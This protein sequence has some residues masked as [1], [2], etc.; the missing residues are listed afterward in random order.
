MSIRTDEYTTTPRVAP[1]DVAGTVDI[2][3]DAVERRG[4]AVEAAPPPDSDGLHFPE[5]NWALDKCGFK[6]GRAI[7]DA[8]PA[9]DPGPIAIIDV[10]YG[11]LD[12]PCIRHVVDE[13]FERRGASSAASHAA[14]V[15][16]VIVS[17]CPVK[18]VQV[19]NSATT[20]GLD[21]NLMLQALRDIASPTSR[22]RVLNLSIGWHARERALNA[23]INECLAKG[24]VVVA[25]MGE[26]EEPTDFVSYPAAI[27]G[28]IAVGATDMHDRRLPGSGTG[29]HIWMAA[30]GEDIPT[31][32]GANTFGV[33]QGTSFATA[34]VSAAAWLA[35]RANQNLTSAQVRQ[36]LGKSADS[37]MV[38]ACPPAMKGIVPN[39]K[40]NA[41]IGCGRLDVAELA[42]VV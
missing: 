39:D 35:V 6:K 15:T 37:R 9:A 4:R 25:A 27:P 30:P 14:E 22:V 20:A 5:D 41:A 3:A 1:S 38:E 12:H 34:L 33:R 32:T 36:A 7:L 8:R 19:Y 21:T 2:L 11:A 16:G 31:V 17:A 40:W 23:A 24:V 26:Y 29:D 10:G 28:V 42:K 13:R 18:K